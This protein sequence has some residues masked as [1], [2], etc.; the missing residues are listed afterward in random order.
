MS[1]V[2]VMCIINLL[3]SRGLKIFL[4]FLIMVVVCVYI[5]LLIVYG[6]REIEL[7]KQQERHAELCIFLNCL[8]IVTFLFLAFIIYNKINYY[9]DSDNSDNSD[10]DVHTSS[11]IFIFIIS[12]SI[13]LFF[14]LCSCLLIC[15]IDFNC[16]NLRETPLQSSQYF[17]GL[18]FIAHLGLLCFVIVCKIIYLLIS[19][20]VL[21]FSSSGIEDIRFYSHNNNV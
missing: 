15:N 5:I 4:L 11:A 13:Y 3:K 2:N 10:N 1:T 6:H 21:K 8:T 18:I 20:C 17:L 9:G 14:F 7:D 19:Y 16:L 12:Y